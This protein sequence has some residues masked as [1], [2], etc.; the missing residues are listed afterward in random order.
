MSKINK[1]GKS[2]FVIAILSFLLVA[3]LA[4]G[5]TYAYFSDSKTA[6][7]SFVTGT[8]KVS[9]LDATAV[10][11]AHSD[12]IVPGSPLINSGVQLVPE[13]TVKTA[14]IAVIE[15][16]PVGD[17]DANDISFTGKIDAKWKPVVGEEGSNVRAFVYNDG[18]NSYIDAAGKGAEANT[19]AID[20]TT[21]TVYLSTAVE[22]GTEHANHGKTLTITVTFYA[23]QYDYLAGE[24]AAA[25]SY[26][27][28]SKVG[29][30]YDAVRTKVHTSLPERVAAAG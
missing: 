22:N 27:G 12:E 30:L 20:F 6:T 23:A 26:A 28:V 19:T 1:L 9:D 7:G 2:T 24:G 25:D 15:I 10:F 5:G 8:I 11:T 18:T 21:G 4:F 17:I 16:T 14:L 29:E 13:V 3:V